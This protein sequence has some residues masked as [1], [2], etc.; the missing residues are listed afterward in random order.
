MYLTAEIRWFYWGTTPQ[1]VHDWLERGI[2]L[3]D[4]QPARQDHYL[5]LPGNA[6]LGIKL[7]E[8]RIEVKQRLR[9]RGTAHFGENV[10]GVVEHWRKWSFP[11]STPELDPRTWLTPATSWIAVDKVRRLQRYRWDTDGTVSV[12]RLDRM[13]EWGC[14]FELSEVRAGGGR[15]WSVCFEAFGEEARLDDGLYAVAS[16]FLQS[17]PVVMEEEQSIGYPAWLSLLRGSA[18]KPWWRTRHPAQ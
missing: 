3:P 7:R 16:I 14:E 5:H 6:S 4:V 1:A 17:W 2:G 18:S 8:G 10:A 11:I 12:V 9:Q 13:P 15:W